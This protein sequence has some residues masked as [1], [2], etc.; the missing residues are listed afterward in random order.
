MIAA[1]EAQYYE[2]LGQF[3]RGTGTVVELGPWLGKS[4]R[5]IVAGLRSSPCFTRQKLHVFDDFVWRPDWMDAY[6]HPDERLPRHANFQPLFEKYAGDLSAEMIVQRGRISDYDGNESL[7]S[8]DYNAGPIELL[9]VDCGRTVAANEAWWNRLSPWFM[10]GKT[11]IIMQDWRL[12][13]ELPPK[14]YN[15]TRLFTDSKLDAIEL[16]HEVESG[17]IG[18]FVYFGES[19]R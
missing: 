4:T 9:F 10:P 3:Y 12:H 13:R 7:E 16:L 2:Y 11:L 6:V 14:W 1:E 15:Q 18:T 8:I 19:R 5:H 17:G